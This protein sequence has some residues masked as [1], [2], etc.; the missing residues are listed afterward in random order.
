MS[1]FAAV[2]HTR[3]KEVYTA[4]VSNT[5]TSNTQKGGLLNMCLNSITL[6]QQVSKIS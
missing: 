3:V 5:Q 4:K 6:Q 1:V 2:M